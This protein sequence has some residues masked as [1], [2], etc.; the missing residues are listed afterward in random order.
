MKYC[1]LPAQY[2]KP[3]TY[4]YEM[5]N[6]KIIM[7]GSSYVYDRIP[8][9]GDPDRVIAEGSDNGYASIADFYKEVCD[10][11]QFNPFAFTGYYINEGAAAN[12]LYKE[13]I[14]G[15]T[16]EFEVTNIGPDVFY[17]GEI[18]EANRIGYFALDQGDSR[19]TNALTGTSSFSPWFG[20]LI[21]PY[22]ELAENDGIL[23]RFEIMPEAAFEDGTFSFAHHF[24]HEGRIRDG[25]VKLYVWKAS[26]KYYWRLALENYTYTQGETDYADAH[27]D[28]V[29]IGHVYNP[30]NPYDDEQKDGTE[31]GNGGFDNDTDPVDVPPLPTMDITS[32]GGLKLYKL[33]PSDFAALMGYLMSNAPGDAVLKWF[34]NPIQG[35]VS[36][37]VLP[38]PVSVNGAASITVLGLPTGVSA[39]TAKQWTEYNMGSVLVEFGFGNNFLDYSPWTKI[40]IYLPFIGIRQLN[41]DEVIGKT[42]G[43]HYQFD[44]VSGACIA[45]VKVGNAVRYAFAGS[46]ACGV[47]LAQS[48]WGQFYI[49]AATTA[50]GALAGAAGGAAAAVAEGESG[51]GIAAGTAMGA[52]KGGGSLSGLN[53]K[54]TIARSGAISG[55]GAELG[56][57]YPY[58]IIERPDKAKVASPAPVT[59]ITC[60]RTLSLGSLSG[61]NVIEHVHLHG[62]GATAEEL[63]EIER[64]LYEGVVF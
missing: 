17:P 14:E 42:V 55:A 24:R 3:G 61:Y 58:L 60:G 22:R 63:D 1:Y 33:T 31:G 21:T 19:G 25:R 41:T 11:L 50:A 39:Y 47:P 38:Y 15:F 51:A 45:F 36:C 37:Y 35:I 57:P 40:S 32:A 4:P 2:P 44:N 27:F 20:S 53:A 6:Y 12:P 49:A 26:D 13:L 48:N 29:D 9:P 10:A 28:D 5:L 52:V 59:G 64:L 16:G 46:C 54:P 43:V 8:L 7:Y 18:T 34:Q 23:Y 62:I 30:A 56:V